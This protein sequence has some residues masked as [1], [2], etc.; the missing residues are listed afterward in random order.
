MTRLRVAAV[1]V[2]VLVLAVGPTAALAAAQ[3]PPEQPGQLPVGACAPPAKSIH[4]KETWA[5]RRMAP[6]RVWRLTEGSGIVGV[7]D[8]GV[9]A[10]IPALEGAVLPGSN[11]AGGRG[12]DDCYGR[13]TFIAGLIAG[14]PSEQEKNPF[15]GMA[16]G[17]RVFPVRVT[18]DPTKI[19]DHTAYANS[20]ARGIV[21]AVNGGSRVIAVGLVAT[22]NVPALRAAVRLAADRDVV[23]VASAAV[24]KDGQLAFPARL[25]G[26]AAVAPLGP[27]G[28]NERAYYGA[29]PSLAAPSE[30]LVSVVPR[31]G[32]HRT[33]SGAELAVAY[34]AGAAALVRSYHPELTAP[35]VTARL[36]D[37]ADQPSVAVPDKLLG[38]GVVDPFAAVSTMLDTDPPAEQVAEHVTV[39]RAPAPD[40]APANRALWFACGITGA[41]LLIGGPAAVIAAGR[42]RRTG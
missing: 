14:R 30:E 42:R 2:A 31:G 24:P 35:E 13:G 5:Q 40:P 41:A 33:A 19:T 32:G 25:P 10:N 7:V 3:P 37:T 15:A 26:V 11:L 21:A 18:D 22:L 23:V 9:A 29:D 27:D 34:V 20:I 38:H 1:A 16:P 8:T 17:A 12:N 28:P 39:P 4:R 6:E 36:R